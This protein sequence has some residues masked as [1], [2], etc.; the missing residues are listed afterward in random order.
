MSFQRAAANVQARH[1]DVV[2]AG[3]FQKS[4]EVLRAVIRE[5]VADSQDPEGV[6]IGRQREILLSALGVQRRQGGEHQQKV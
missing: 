5:T 6:G 3:G 1:D 2:D 4:W